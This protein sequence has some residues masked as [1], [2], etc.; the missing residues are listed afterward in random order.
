MYNVSAFWENIS[1]GF[2]ISD[3]AAYV[4]FLHIGQ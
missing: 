4:E 2:V 1:V 3:T